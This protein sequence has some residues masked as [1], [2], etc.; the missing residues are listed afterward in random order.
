MCRDQDMDM[1]L[2]TLL[3]RIYPS[4]VMITK[5]EHLVKN[6]QKAIQGIIQV[7]TIFFLLLIKIY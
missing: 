3:E 6:P 5:F 1:R 2:S 7:R 4:K